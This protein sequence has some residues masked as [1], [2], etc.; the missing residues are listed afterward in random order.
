[1][2][3][4]LVIVA[5]ALVSLV[6]LVR[7][8][9]VQHLRSFGRPA[10]PPPNNS[11]DEAIDTRAMNARDAE[12]PR[13]RAS[14]LAG[15]EGTL[16]DEAEALVLKESEGGSVGLGSVVRGVR[17]WALGGCSVFAL[18]VCFYSLTFCFLSSRCT[19]PC[20][21][22]AYAVEDGRR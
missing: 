1:M 17:W 13:L 9:V 20:T 2:S 12:V 11:V 19:R 3:S 14:A 15:S 21:V 7:H 22:Q 4:S 16:W 6:L 10:S 5:A 18:T 8:P